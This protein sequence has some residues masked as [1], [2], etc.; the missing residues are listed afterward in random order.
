MKKWLIVLVGLTLAIVVTTGSVFALT[1]DG[2][3]NSKQDAADQDDEPSG[4]QPPVTSADDI[5][6]NECNWIHNISACEGQELG[7]ED[8][9]EP[10]QGIAIGEPYPDEEK[11]IGELEPMFE[12]GEPRYTVQSLNEAVKDDCDLAG[13]TVYV[14]SEGQLGCVVVHDLKGSGE[15]LIASSQPPVVEPAR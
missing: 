6:P 8:V 2:S 13:G 4:D 1:G 3:D 12:D 5:D 11:N 10:D 7:S 14:T 9:V 15:E